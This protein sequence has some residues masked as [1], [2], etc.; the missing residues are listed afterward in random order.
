MWNKLS[1]LKL[2]LKLIHVYHRQN[3]TWRLS[4]KLQ[5]D[6]LVQER[7][8]SIANTLELRLSCINPSRYPSAE[9]SYPRTWGRRPYYGECKATHDA[10][11]FCLTCHIRVTLSHE[12]HGVSDHRQLD[13]LFHGLFKL[14]TKETSKLCITGPLWKN[15]P[16]TDG[17]PTRMANDAA[18]DFKLKPHHE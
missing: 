12:R 17:F 6:W 3:R 10:F 2:V 8:N 5:I 4:L 16:V 7:R 9:L 14:T 13:R 15:P 11:E 1:L 18:S